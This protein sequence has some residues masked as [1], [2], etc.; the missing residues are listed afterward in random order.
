MKGFI[1]A[2]CKFIFVFSWSSILSQYLIVNA[3]VA[4]CSA[5]KPCRKWALLMFSLSAWRVLVLRLV[6]LLFYCG[7]EFVLQLISLFI[8]QE[9]HSSR[10]QECHSLWPCASPDIRFVNSSMHLKVYRAPVYTYLY[11]IS[12]SWQKPTLANHAQQYLSHA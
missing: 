2:S 7:S 6:H 1:H 5:T 9:R 3:C 12:S 8:S 11:H 4:T 10:S